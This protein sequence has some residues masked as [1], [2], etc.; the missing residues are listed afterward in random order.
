MARISAAL[1]LLGFIMAQVFETGAS[2]QQLPSPKPVSGSEKSENALPPLPPVPRKESTVLGGE[3][4]NVDPVRDQFLL[5]I[6]GEHPLKILYDERTQLYRDG[7]RIPLED[8]QPENRASVQTMLEGSQVFAVSIHILSKAPEGECQGRVLGF[9]PGTGALTIRSPLSPSPIKLIVAQNTLIARAGQGSFSSA[10]SGA[11]DLV[12]GALISI[13]F[14][15]DSYGRSVADSISVLAE[16]GSD[17]AFEGKISSLDLASG[18]MVLADSKDG[19]SYQ[20]FFDPSILAAQNL[21]TG[22]AV[23][24]TAKFDG[25]RYDA[26]QISPH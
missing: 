19:K 12:A 3:I 17:F 11:S 14:K 13:R 21:H 6:I 16:P 15:A 7:V 10:H 5:K 20:L 8:L 4:R 26:T 2:S 25:S 9:D 24:V 22:D 18:Q 23:S 1:V